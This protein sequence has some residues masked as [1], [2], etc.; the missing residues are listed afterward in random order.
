MKKAKQLLALIG[1]IL[2]IG[3]YVSTLVCALCSS[4]NFMNMLMASIYA[5]V[6]I[7]V[8]I[9]AYTLI[10]RLS[11]KEDGKEDNAGDAK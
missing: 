10:Y 3:L 4:E 8:L 1:V 6:I 11:H 7:P 9:W 5:T 2:L